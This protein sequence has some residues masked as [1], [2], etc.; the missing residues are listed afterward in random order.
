MPGA[1]QL[2]SANA[3]VMAD[4]GQQAFVN[5][6][7]NYVNRND[8]RLN[9][10]AQRISGTP[11]PFGGRMGN[12]N[13]GTRL[14]PVYQMRHQAALNHNRGEAGLPAIN[15]PWSPGTE[16]GGGGIG[17]GGPGG[18]I[19]T[20]ITA[21]APFDLANLGRNI[22]TGAPPM[23]MAQT[24]ALGGQA[25]NLMRSGAMDADTEFAR[26]SAVPLAELA[27]DI[28]VGRA[29]V[30]L[31]LGNLGAGMNRYNL[32]AD[33]AGRGIG[34]DRAGMMARLLFG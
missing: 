23:N 9:G 5:A 19:N 12:N 16:P 21:S 2:P 1:F 29:N 8:Q 20:G 4:P 18:T 32:D 28:D 10:L 34:L 6:N 27:N 15:P 26:A 3:P 31:G 7:Q 11:P 25:Q 30:G 33:L 24:Q 14:G 22:L 17:P 13:M